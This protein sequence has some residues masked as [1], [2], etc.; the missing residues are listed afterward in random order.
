MSSGWVLKRMRRTCRQ[1]ALALLRVRDRGVERREQAMALV[2]PSTIAVPVEPPSIHDATISRVS[3][4]R[5]APP[6]AT[7]NWTTYSSFEYAGTRA[8][9]AVPCPE[10]KS[11][12]CHSTSPVTKPRSSWRV[13]VIRDDQK[14]H[15]PH[16]R[17]RGTSAGGMT[18]RICF[19]CRNPRPG[20][21]T[22]MSSSSW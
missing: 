9:I 3:P 5:P 16:P 21:T 18:E 14:P 8:A 7:A 17:F 10:L 13:R 6:A 4:S 15:A 22:P 2:E 19:H 12:G 20:S 11:A 1:V